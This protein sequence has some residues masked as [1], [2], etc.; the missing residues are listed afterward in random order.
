RALSRPYMQERREEIMKGAARELAELKRL[1]RKDGGWNY[2][3]F[4]PYSASFLTAATLVNLC[5]AK[6]LGCDVDSGMIEK[7]KEFIASVKFG[8]GTYMYSPGGGSEN[9]K[10]RSFSPVG[11]SARSPLCELSLLAASAGDRDSLRQ[12]IQNFITYQPILKELRKGSRAERTHT[13]QGRTAPYYYMFGHYWTTRCINQM[14]RTNWASLK[15]MMYGAIVGS[16]SPDG[17]FQDFTGTKAFKVYATALGVLTMHELICAEPDPA[18][19]PAGAPKTAL[20][21][22]KEKAPEEKMQTP[23]TKK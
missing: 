23:T 18:F 4:I 9:I 7:A 14:P 10:N 6:N 16:Q 20:T 19:T 13:G 3:N 2:Y 11:A 5:A 21:T 1:Q 22:D 12:A 15:N 8:K 17:T